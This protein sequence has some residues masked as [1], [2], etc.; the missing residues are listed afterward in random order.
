MVQPLGSRLA[1]L[2]DDIA[3]FVL[4]P[5]L[6]AECRGEAAATLGSVCPGAKRTE[7]T[8]LT[9]LTTRE[10]QVVN[11]AVNGLLKCNSDRK[12][13]AVILA[14]YLSS[15]DDN[16]RGAAAVGLRDLGADS[17]VVLTSMLQALRIEQDADWC[18]A[19]AEALAAIGPATIRPLMSIVEEWDP[20]VSH[21]AVETLGIVGKN[22]PEEIAREMMSH[23]DA[24]MRAN[25]ILLLRNMGAVAAPAVPFLA[26]ALDVE[27]DDETTVH[28]IFAIAACGFKGKRGIEALLRRLIIT[29][30]EEIA[31]YAKQCLRNC[32]EPAKPLIVKALETASGRAQRDLEWL[33]GG[34]GPSVR[35]DFA[36][37]AELQRDD[38]ITIFVAVGQVLTAQGA[39]SWRGI[40]RVL[41]GSLM[42]VRQNGTQ[43]GTTAN[44]LPKHVFELAELLKTE[45]T[46][47]IENHKETD[48]TDAGR[49]WLKS[50]REYLEWKAKRGVHETR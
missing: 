48:L 30:N 37:L 2:A 13:I 46:A 11:G 27:E 41:H 34:A 18:A 16:L 6:S 24:R 36:M 21:I 20:H 22:C 3:K 47:S 32:G 39:T 49:K 40:S 26:S 1:G 28:L 42:I 31:N 4:D 14:G 10:W 12:K 23:P 25:C 43:M 19:L 44:S 35:S 29:N 45:L 7:K 5:S 50:C 15:S 8:L 33:L 9:A 38:L 17:A